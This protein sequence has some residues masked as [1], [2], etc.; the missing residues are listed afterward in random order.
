MQA[1]VQKDRLTPGPGSPVAATCNEHVVYEHGPSVAHARLQADET[2]QLEQLA[3][4]V[5][6]RGALLPR[7]LTA[8]QRRA[9]KATLNKPSKISAQTWMT[10]FFGLLCLSRGPFGQFAGR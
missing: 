7:N 8:E 9:V 10:Q 1:G 5:A 4:N 2:A 3:R 6:N